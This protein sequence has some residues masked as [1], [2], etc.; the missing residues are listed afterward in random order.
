MRTLVRNVKM[1]MGYPVCSSLN[2]CFSLG[3]SA[4]IAEIG[5][6]KHRYRNPAERTKVEKVLRQQVTDGKM[7]SETITTGGA[8]K[9]VFILLE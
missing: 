1:K 2:M 9:E 3:G 6:R 4:S 5:Q 7:K 8:P